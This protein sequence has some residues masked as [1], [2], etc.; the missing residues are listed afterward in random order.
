M[1][2]K[3]LCLFSLLFL[4]GETQTFFVETKGMSSEFQLNRKKHKLV[5]IV[6]W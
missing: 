6:G 5:E 1:R 2:G 4:D 3:V